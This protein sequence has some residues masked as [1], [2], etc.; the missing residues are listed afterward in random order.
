MRNMPGPFFM[1]QPPWA[2]QGPENRSELFETVVPARVEK[3]MQ[4]LA[5]LTN[6]TR[7]SAAV[8]ENQIETI[9][10]QTLTEEEQTASATACNLLSA[11]FAGKLP[12]D[13][14]EQMRYEALEKQN[15]QIGKV[16]HVKTGRVLHC[17]VCQGRD[18]QC[19]LCEGTGKIMVTP[20]GRTDDA[21][22]EN[23]ESE[24]M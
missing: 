17:L 23:D 16:S 3:A 4:F 15:S 21:D 13:Q 11:Y 12:P 14:W 10:G 6:K 20:L 24:I 5:M 19:S 18:S 2:H 1:I 9:P 8:S 7:T 22:N